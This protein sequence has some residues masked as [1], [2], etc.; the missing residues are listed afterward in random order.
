MI[1]LIISAFILAGCASQSAKPV[2][3]APA[4]SLYKKNPMSVALF[5]HG[6]KPSNQYKILGTEKVSEYNLVGVK[7]Q[8]AHIRDMMRNLAAN[9]GGDAVID[10]EQQDKNI[11]GT[12]IAF[13]VPPNRNN[14]KA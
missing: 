10:I 12:V 5:T 9:L 6:K 11:I 14:N 7:R 3:P 1:S 2:A 8:E 4:L 13:E